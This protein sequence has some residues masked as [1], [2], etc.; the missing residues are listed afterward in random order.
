MLDLMPLLIQLKNQGSLRNLGKLAYMCWII[1]WSLLGEHRVASVKPIL[2]SGLNHEEAGSSTSL[3]G[4]EIL[5]ESKELNEKHS[6][7]P[8][9]LGVDQVK[10]VVSEMIM[11]RRKGLQLD[12]LHENNNKEFSNQSSELYNASMTNDYQEKM[13]RENEKQ[14]S[15]A[16]LFGNINEDNLTSTKELVTLTG[17]NWN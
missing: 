2:S 7:P 3:K 14:E 5:R 11:Q 6:V 4:K 17:S 8:I 16:D 12:D 13:K 15:S 10:F 9:V 1:R